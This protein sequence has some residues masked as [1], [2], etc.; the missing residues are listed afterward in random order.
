MGGA[1]KHSLFCLSVVDMARS[2]TASLRSLLDR[3]AAPLTFVGYTL[4]QTPIAD[5]V[6]RRYVQL[7][8]YTNCANTSL[9]LFL[10]RQV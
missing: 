7:Q 5:A 6:R 10:E 4:L 2:R 3:L 1:T 8:C 9:F